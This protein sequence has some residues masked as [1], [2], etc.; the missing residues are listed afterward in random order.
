MLIKRT[1]FLIAA[2]ISSSVLPIPE[3]T[4]LSLGIPAFL[5]FKSSPIDT[6]SAPEP[7]FFNSLSIFKFAFDFTEKQIIGLIA[8]KAF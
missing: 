3:K 7:S 8:L 6:T 4:I 5:A 1:F 2:V